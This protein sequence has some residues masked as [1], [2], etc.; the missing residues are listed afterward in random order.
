M[1]AGEAWFEYLS[2]GERDL[3]VQAYDLLAREKREALRRSGSSHRARS[4][5]GD[6]VAME[7][8][9]TLSSDKGGFH[10]YSFVVFPMAKAFEGFLKQVFLEAGLITEATYSGDRFRI[11]KSLN[12]AL[13]PRARGIWWLY[14]PLREQCGEAVPEELWTAWKDCRNLLFHFFPQHKHF[15]TLAEAELRLTQLKEAMAAMLACE[16]HKKKT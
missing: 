14:G 1:F 15:I 7:S 11:G 13:P 10:D 2:E 5:Q 3:V 4:A 12:P 9:A 8:L 6:K 16:M